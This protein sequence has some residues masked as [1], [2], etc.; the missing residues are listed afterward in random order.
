MSDRFDFLEIDESRRSR[1][2]R[3]EPVAAT[4]G[5]KAPTASVEPATQPADARIEPSHSWRV[6]ETIG[7]P[8]SG[9]GEF[10]APSGIA[11]DRLSTLYVADTLNHRVQRIAADGGVA[12]LDAARGAPREPVGVV[13]DHDLNFY[14]IDR[15]P[16]LIYGYSS[17]G[18]PL[19]RW[20]APGARAGDL[21]ASS[22][23]A[24]DRGGLVLADTGNGRLLRIRIPQ[25][26]RRPS[27]DEEIGLGALQS[28]RAVC[29]D[30]RGRL[31]AAEANRPE[32]VAFQRSSSGRW[33]VAWRRS[34]T[35]AGFPAR[36]G[37]LTVAADREACVFVA[38]PHC[39][40]ARLSPD[41]DRLARLRLLGLPEEPLPSSLALGP[42]GSLYTT[43]LSGRIYR[44]QPAE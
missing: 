18:E 6:V 5:G 41:E 1:I 22:V 14:V 19:W 44:L 43:S 29:V 40:W 21:Q 8:G 37:P 12:I 17:E 25:G 13:V 33:E 35:D 42:D 24:V 31:I 34:L 32:L 39:G 2:R 7:R 27:V 4:A 23:L 16:G 11:V 10:R 36:T 15:T 28:P 3:A 20:G 9:V 26:G 30:T 38:V